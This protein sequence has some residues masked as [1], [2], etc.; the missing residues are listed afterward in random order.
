AVK[1]PLEEISLI[2][3][4]ILSDIIVE[5][6]STANKVNESGKISVRSRDI[7]LNDATRKRIA[8]A[9]NGHTKTERV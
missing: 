1:S 7:P 5:V 3:I 6:K 4:S 9:R 2:P 8:V